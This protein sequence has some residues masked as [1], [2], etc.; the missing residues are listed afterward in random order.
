MVNNTNIDIINNHIEDAR[1]LTVSTSVMTVGNEIKT[2]Y[3]GQTD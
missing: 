1:P 2:P 3:D